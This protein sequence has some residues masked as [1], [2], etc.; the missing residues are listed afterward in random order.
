[1]AETS[2]SDNPKFLKL[3]PGELIPWE[4]KKSE[5]PK[6]TGDE[7]VFEKVWKDIEK[8]GNRFIWF[9]LTDS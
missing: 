9:C 4:R 2:K 8:I 7:K 3:K 1:M 6:I 5:Y